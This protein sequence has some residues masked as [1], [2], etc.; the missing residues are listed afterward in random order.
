MTAPIL[1]LIVG[2][3]GAGKSTL[4]STAIEGR[5]GKLEFVNAD[6]LAMAKFG[7][8]AETKEEAAYGQKAAERRRAVLLAARR[9][10][11]AE[12]VFSHESKLELIRDA[13]ARGFEVWVY[14]VS[15][16]TPT[17]AIKRIQR[18][19]KEGGH[20]VPEDK[21]RARYERNQPLIR[22]AIERADRGFVFDNSDFGKPPRRVL[23]YVK[24]E[25]VFRHETLPNWARTIYDV[26]P[27]KKLDTWQGRASASFEEAR[28]LVERLLGTNARLYGARRE[29]GAVYEGTVIGVTELHVVQQISAVSAVA[30]FKDALNANT[31]QKSAT[32]IF[33]EYA[34]RGGEVTV[35]GEGIVDARAGKTYTGR[36]IA[37]GTFGVL[38][39]VG[40]DRVRHP[41]SA[42]L[43][44]KGGI[45]SGANVKITYSLDKEPRV[46]VQFLEVRFSKRQVE[47]GKGR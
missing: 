16:A 38:Q 8:N 37:I 9:D 27:G 19:V 32:P 35:L 26:E 45:R 5:F 18:R 28:A 25:A 20:D 15:V 7:H 17:L 42:G 30:H 44:A 22:K 39:R 46:S 10:F 12:T 36:V 2:P 6:R 31:L 11:V 41:H 24:G 13:Q 23:E 34:G 14:H 33:V 43:H 29:D 40:L 3:N 1:H 21:A 47:K 4:Y